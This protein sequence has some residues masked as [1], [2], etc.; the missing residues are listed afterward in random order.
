MSLFISLYRRR[1]LGIIDLNVKYSKSIAIETMNDKYGTVSSFFN[2]WTILLYRSV[3]LTVLLKVCV[4][5]R[6]SR[7]EHFKF[8]N[9]SS[10]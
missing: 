10:N 2:D 5:G 4:I 8:S 7:I 6:N 3:S 1:I 9:C